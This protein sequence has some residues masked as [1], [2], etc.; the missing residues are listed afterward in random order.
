MT[1]PMAV[2]DAFYGLRTSPFSLS[3]NPQ[4]LF[5]SPRHREALAGLLYVIR[6]AKGFAV[7][8]GEVGTGK[9]T[10]VHA[11]LTQLGGHARSAVLFNPNL[12]RQDL[13]AHL[14]AEFGLP[15]ERSGLGALR[16]LQKF[17][18]QQF[19]A[20]VRVVV[21]IDE[22]HALA[23][24]VLEEIRLLSNF[25]T[26]ECKLLQVLLVGQPELLR[27]SAMRH[28]RQLR[29]R[30]ALRFELAPLQFQ[31]TIQYVR[32]RLEVAGAAHD[33]F[34][35]GAYAALYRF[36]GGLPRLINIL[37]DN[38]LLSG[39]ARDEPHIGRTRVY[40]AARDLGLSPLKRL[41]VWT[42]IAARYHERV[43]GYTLRTV[44]AAALHPLRIIK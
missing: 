44:A 9:T 29:Q 16:A 8:T 41:P 43:Q 7:L 39:Y 25:E 10:I 13:Y 27:R 6:D 37:S 32:A 24:D 14:L 26:S 3:P 22:A 34:L 40:D 31:E 2:Y 23:P 21:V 20:G 5:L 4:F 38:A 12:L 19:E 36:S 15:P 42:R 11:L 30:V 17:L 18:L 35:P 1:E 33:I 28:M